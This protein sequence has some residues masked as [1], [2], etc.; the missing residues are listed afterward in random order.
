MVSYPKNL[1]LEAKAFLQACNK[2]LQEQLA[3]LQQDWLT[4]PCLCVSDSV[5]ALTW[6]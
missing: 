3:S 1:Q 5:S 4:V 2:A 6:R